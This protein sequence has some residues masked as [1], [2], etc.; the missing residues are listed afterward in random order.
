M[1]N[2]AFNDVKSTAFKLDAWY[3]PTADNSIVFT[4]DTYYARAA[5]GL[6]AHIPALLSNV[7]NEGAIFIEPYASSFPSGT[8]ADVASDTIICPIGK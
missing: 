1:R 4:N 7:N 2:A 3:T 8:T 6:F 5:K